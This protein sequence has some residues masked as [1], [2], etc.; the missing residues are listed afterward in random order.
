MAPRSLFSTLEYDNVVIRVAS[1]CWRGIHVLHRA[2]AQYSCWCCVG[3]CIYVKR[4]MLN[5]LA[6]H[7]HSCSSAAIAKHIKHIVKSPV[8]QLP[9]LEAMVIILLS[10]IVP[11][12]LSQLQASGPAC[13]LTRNS[14]ILTLN[15]PLIAHYNVDGCKGYQSSSESNGESQN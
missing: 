3:P 1:Y 8:K 11:W 12:H 15:K 2:L 14:C 9:R 7:L 4:I 6:S 13:L 10:Y 5:A